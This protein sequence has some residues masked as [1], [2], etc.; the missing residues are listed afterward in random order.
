MLLK[1]SKG[2]AIWASAKPP[3]FARGCHVSTELSMFKPRVDEFSDLDL[4][5]KLDDASRLKKKTTLRDVMHVSCVVLLCHWM[6]V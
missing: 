3:R 1:Y 5:W 4:T 2:S 6:P